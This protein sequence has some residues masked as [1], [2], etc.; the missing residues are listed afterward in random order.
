MKKSLITAHFWT[1]QQ[2]GTAEKATS[3]LSLIKKLDG[4]KWVPDKWG[5]FE[6][7]KDVFV[8]DNEARLVR[9][10]TEE[11]HGRIS[12]S[13]LFTKRKPSLFMDVTCWRGRVPDLNYLW[14]D[15]DASEFVG[16]EGID[17]LTRTIT[18]F[19]SWSG[20]VYATAFAC[21]DYPEVAC[22][23]PKF[24]LRQTINSTA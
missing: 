2:L 17:R 24:D 23:V 21:D 22:R 3:F 19:I 1:E 6:P 13:I 15:M 9:E 4:G 14:F 11:R 10:W 5:Q 18:Q 16:A 8:Q 12:N 20:A 7:I